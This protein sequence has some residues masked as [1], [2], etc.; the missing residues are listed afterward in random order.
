MKVP[1][2]E[3][4]VE[5]ANLLNPAFGAILLRDAVKDYAKEDGGMHIGLVHLLLPVVL[6]KSTRNHLPSTTRTKLHVWIQKY[7][8]VRVGFT[9]RARQLVPYTK[10][11]LLFALQREILGVEKKT[12]IDTKA[13]LKT[14][15]GPEE[16]EHN[17][18]RKRAAF[19]GRWYARSGTPSLIFQAWGV[20]P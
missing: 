8:E 14:L 5:I 17:I 2:K 1:W 15:P 6:H 10:E 3:R 4:P 13:R 16:A 19:L 7:P 11:A 12:I 9:K 20:R 18:C